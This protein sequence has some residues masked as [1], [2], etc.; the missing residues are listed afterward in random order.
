MN[1]PLRSLPNEEN[2][3]KRLIAIG[4]AATGILTAAVW[5][6][7][8]NEPPAPSKTAGPATSPGTSTLGQMTPMDE[9]MKKMQMLHDQMSRATASEE[10]QKLL[11]E[12][13][14][15][16]QEG[17]GMMDKSGGAASRM[18]MMRMH[19]EMMEMMQTRMGMMQLMMQAMMDQQGMIAGPSSPNRT[20]KK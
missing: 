15:A 4:L 8:I 2:F 20:P 19:M 9:Q 17:M 7:D 6:Q 13:R 5:A 1:A 3:M 14:K 18:Q 16:M 11:E 10:R 12:Q